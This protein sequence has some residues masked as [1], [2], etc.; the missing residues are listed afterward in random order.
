MNVPLNMND[1][2]LKKFIEKGEQFLNEPGAL[3]NE[4][5]EAGYSKEKIDAFISERR[6]KESNS[7]KVV[8]QF[9]S[10]LFTCLGILSITGYFGQS[11]FGIIAGLLLCFAALAMI[12]ISVK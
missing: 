9:L 1:P 12:K 8:A 11:T 3:Y 2:E 7:F 10:I 4:L 6:K 5:I